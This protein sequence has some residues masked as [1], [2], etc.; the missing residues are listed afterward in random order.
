RHSPAVHD[1]PFAFPLRLHGSGCSRARPN[2][3][4]RLSTGIGSDVTR[5]A[6]TPL[7]L[8]APQIG[9]PPRVTFIVIRP[10]TPAMPHAEERAPAA[11][12]AGDSIGP[13]DIPSSATDPMAPP[14]PGSAFGDDSSD[15]D[16][17]PPELVELVDTYTRRILAGE[18][19]DPRAL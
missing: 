18:P 3:L 14:A 16:G 2:G 13:A 19:L 5:G 7:G 11:M 9:A 6:A 17:L 15:V 10:L 12:V 4:S 8:A 1:R